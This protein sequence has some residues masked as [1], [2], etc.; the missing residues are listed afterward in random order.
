MR[1]L[2]LF[3]LVLHTSLYANQSMM[4]D[5]ANIPSD[6]NINQIIDLEIQVNKHIIISRGER[7]VN[8]NS[9]SDSQTPICTL[10]MKEWRIF[11]RRLA[12][13]KRVIVATSNDLVSY[14]NSGN[15]EIHPTVKID[16]SD[17]SISM[18]DCFNVYSI[19]DLAIALNEYA[20]LSVRYVEAEHTDEEN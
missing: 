15:L 11:N 19:S 17:E 9:N 7:R 6:I 5:A 3:S 14:D 4:V 8:L 12:A 2:I 18:L 16:G 20:T 13:G 10:F 1:F